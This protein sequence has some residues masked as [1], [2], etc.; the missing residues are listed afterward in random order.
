MSTITRSLNCPEVAVLTP[1]PCARDPQ[2]VLED[3]QQ[4]NVSLE[5]AATDYGVI[6]DPNTMMVDEAATQAC[7]QE[8]EV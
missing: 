8:M 5:R 4:G 3:V 6:I 2:R 7:R 1:L